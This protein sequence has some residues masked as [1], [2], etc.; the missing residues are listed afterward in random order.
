MPARVSSSRIGIT[1]I[2]GYMPAPSVSRLRHYRCR[3][4]LQPLYG[5]ERAI[6]SRQAAQT[7][8]SRRA[9][10]VCCSRMRTSMKFLKAAILLSVGTATVSFAQSHANPAGLTPLETRMAAAVDAGSAADRTLLEQLVNTNSGTMHLAGVVAVKDAL[11]PRLQ[12]LGFQ[13]H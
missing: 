8:Q 9:D 4:C 7:A 5:A 12:A 13:V 2:S 6:A 10:R 3:L 11:V 1:I